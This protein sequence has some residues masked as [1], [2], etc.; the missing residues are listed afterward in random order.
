M[1][2]CCD[3]REIRN[4]IIIDRIVVGLLDDTVSERLQLDAR[5]TLTI[6]RQSEEVH[7]QQT[8]V[9]HKPMDLNT[10]FVDEIHSSRGINKQGGSLHYNINKTDIQGLAK[11]LPQ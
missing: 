7:K 4:K 5:L 2:N 8:V 10:D 6:A 1:A 11:L 9:R 3:Y